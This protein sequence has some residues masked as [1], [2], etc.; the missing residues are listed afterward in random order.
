[1]VDNVSQRY[2]PDSFKIASAII[3]AFRDGHLRIYQLRKDI[4][5]DTAVCKRRLK[6]VR[7]HLSNTKLKQWEGY[8]LN[9][10]HDCVIAMKCE[11]RQG[12]LYKAYVMEDR[13][14][15]LSPGMVLGRFELSA[16]GRYFTDFL[17]PHTGARRFVYSVFRNDTV[18][19]TDAE[20]KWEKLKN[21][22]APILPALSMPFERAYGKQ[23]ATKTYLIGLPQ[24]SPENMEILDSLVAADSSRIATCENLIIDARNNVGG[25]RSAYQ[26][27]L[28]FVCTDTIKRIRFRYFYTHDY[29]AS[30]R[31]ELQ[32]YLERGAPDSAFVDW[33]NQEIQKGTDSAGRTVEAPQ[34]YYTCEG[35]RLNPRHI[36]VIV[37]YGCQSAA[38][39]LLIEFKQSHKVTVFG[40]Q[41]MGVVD[42]LDWFYL[43]TP[44]NKYRLYIPY[45]KRHE[46]SGPPHLDGK[47][48]SP[49]VLIPENAPDWIGFVQRYYENKSR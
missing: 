41:T 25:G 43:P 12:R 14:G 4:P 36:G 8:W 18:I 35:V 27:L 20:S 24:C 46:D 30:R 37:N 48:I 49:D 39:L 19:T 44:R 21:Y 16:D 1:M 23:L 34:E 31:A 11:D 6:D 32:A 7:K 5:T 15:V 40:E 45:S 47:G 9:D 10:Y 3:A 2:A 22:N 38:E 26:S 29:A 42:N 13:R 28:P 33:Y 17:N